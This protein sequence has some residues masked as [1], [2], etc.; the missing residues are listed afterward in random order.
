MLVTHGTEIK[1]I[2]RILREGIR[3]SYDLC[4]GETQRRGYPIQDWL[5]REIANHWIMKGISLFA[6]P[7]YDLKAG[8][9][10]SYWCMYKDAACFTVKQNWIRNNAN[11]FRFGWDLAY[12][13][14][15]NLKKSAKKILNP[16]GITKKVTGQS[17]IDEELHR[18]VLVDGPKG[19]PDELTCMK[20]I[21]VNALEGLILPWDIPLTEEMQQE[22]NKYKSMTQRLK[23]YTA[24]YSASETRKLYRI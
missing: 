21:P 15:E 24:P 19:L 14:R 8:R 3:S 6:E 7:E 9:K 23:I 12:E 20:P 4:I 1:N 13:G 2:D 18:K 22:V 11:D 16:L 17:T 5:I 10:I